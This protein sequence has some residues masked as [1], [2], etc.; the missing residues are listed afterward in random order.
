M[1]KTQHDE[2]RRSARRFQVSWDVAVKGT[3]QAGS[4]FDEA[5]TLEN[6]SSLGAFLYLPRRVNLGERLELR[7]KLPFK[8]N[9]WMTY[10]A[11][12]VRLEQASAR[13]GVG[14]RFDTAVP[15]FVAR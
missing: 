4:G 1:G 7:I 8:R 9:N 5:G 6:L 14:V 3:D 15:V 11:E 2:E 12:V 13:A 10:M